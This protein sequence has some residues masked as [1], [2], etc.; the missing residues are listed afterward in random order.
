MLV[1]QAEKF[2]DKGDV[3]EGGA[4]DAAT[5]SR[6]RTL[7]K[8]MPSPNDGEHA[9]WLA[10]KTEH[11]VSRDATVMPERLTN[12]M[13]AVMKRHQ[14]EVRMFEISYYVPC[15]KGDSEVGEDAKRVQLGGAWHREN[16]WH[17]SY[18]LASLFQ[19]SRGTSS[20]LYEYWCKRGK[21]MRHA[22]KTT[23]SEMGALDFQHLRESRRS[24][25]EGVKQWIAVLKEELA[26]KYNNK[27]K[28]QMPE[29]PPDILQQMAARANTDFLDALLNT[30]NRICR[31]NLFRQET[32]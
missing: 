22:K 5:A 32:G 23:Q 18:T 16:T 30:R 21:V 12:T 20:E 29:I 13:D 4:I 3:D 2:F 19:Y 1:S 9:A 25:K 11:G 27:Y 17:T 28:Q 6:L 15:E 31:R 10:H 8:K 7:L 14:G 26:K 24:G